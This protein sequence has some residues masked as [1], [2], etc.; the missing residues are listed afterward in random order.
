VSLNGPE[1]PAFLVSPPSTP[2]LTTRGAGCH[3]PVDRRALPMHL[4]T[5][6]AGQALATSQWRIHQPPVHVPQRS[7]LR[8]LP[9]DLVSPV[10]GPGVTN[11]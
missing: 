7:P 3:R 11:Q 8:P 4:V 9:P 6:A 10:A 1:R 5:A 2:A